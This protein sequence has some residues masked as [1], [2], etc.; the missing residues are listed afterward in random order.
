MAMAKGQQRTGSAGNSQ[1]SSFV[2][3]Y[4]AGYARLSA[5]SD[6]LD[7]INV[8]PVADG[9]TGR[10]LCISLAPLREMDAGPVESVKDRLIRAATGNS[11]NIAAA[12]LTEFLAA[13]H[14]GG[15]ADAAAAG[16][17]EARAAVGNPV[18]GTMLDVFD[19][20][21]EHL[22]DSI[23]NGHPLT[24]R[25]LP[26]LVQAVQETMA[27]LPVLAQAGVIDAGALA[28]YL[29]FEGFFNKMDNRSLP[30]G[31]LPA[32][33]GDLSRHRA[34][35]PR[36]NPPTSVPDEICVNALVA[37]SAGTDFT[38][39]RRHLDRLGESVVV[40][41]DE[42]ALKV[43]LHA[44]DL[45][46]AEDQL[47]GL[48]T[49]EAMT[50]EAL[51]GALPIDAPLP[52]GPVHIMTDA[53]GS[54]SRDRA[55]QLGVTLL[56]SFVVGP[57]GAV[58]ETL[59]DP[60]Q[61]YRR[62]RAGERMGTAQAANMERHQRYGAALERFKRVL[63]LGVGSAYTGNVAAARRWRQA[64]DPEGCLTVFDT[65]AASGKLGLI[66]LATARI[67]SRAASAG[68]VV[69][70]AEHAAAA[71]EELVFLDQLKYLAA[72]GRISKT[73]GFF[74]D[75]L[76]LK[77]V[78]SP[79]PGGVEKVAVVRRTSEQLPLALKH[80]KAALENA[81]APLMLLQYTD[82]RERVANDIQ[83]VLET[84][85]P[86]AEILVSPLSLTAGVHMGPGTWA[87]AWLKD[88]E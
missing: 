26:P 40:L 28:M 65:G 59:L 45:A 7:E 30:A 1:A 8:F 76:R 23:D 79:R 25:L 81:P 17:H 46:A 3:A 47:A 29:F 12:F 73:G 68:L 64:N 57:G 20:L 53:A 14:L 52:P 49:I 34:P 54:L 66:A 15:L 36:S 74:G 69:R 9:D 6:L 75:L 62:M 5:W 38:A 22:A 37:P 13:I 63:Y 41:G 77:P 58:P 27:R 4:A 35:V 44:R 50:G 39:L 32:A 42:R 21:A 83:P 33:F 11:G 78:I 61:V 72:G 43:H 16:A 71:C 24:D 70:F 31:R 60:E 51:Y 18:D 19:T 85:F 84:Q 55:R 67:A 82:N 2:P 86:S 88:G 87:V 48:G 56:D 10:N 80:L